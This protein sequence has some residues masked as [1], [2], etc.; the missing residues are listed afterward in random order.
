MLDLS[1]FVACEIEEN[2]TLQQGITAW[3]DFIMLMG[4]WLTGD[5]GREL[6][7]YLRPELVKSGVAKFFEVIRFA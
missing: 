3:Q 2:G 5:D 6:D 7:D 1:T 4:K